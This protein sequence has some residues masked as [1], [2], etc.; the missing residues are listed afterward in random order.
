MLT[1][2]PRRAA[3]ACVST[4]PPPSAVA[5]GHLAAVELH[6]LAHA[7]QAVPAAVARGAGAVAVVAD[8]DPQLVGG[9][10]DVDVGAGRP[11]RA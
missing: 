11:A 9:V 4:K 2:R 3:G 1:A 6:A 10:A 5:G 7:D 8:L